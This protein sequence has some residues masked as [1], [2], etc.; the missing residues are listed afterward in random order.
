MSSPKSIMRNFTNCK[1]IMFKLQKHGLSIL[2]WAEIS[3]S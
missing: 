1:I 2:S 3:S